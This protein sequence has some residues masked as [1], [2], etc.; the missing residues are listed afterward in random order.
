M[1]DVVD[2]KTRSRMMSDI[3]GKDTRL[4]MLVRSGLHRLGFRFRLHARNLPG[5]PDLVLRKHSAVVFVHGCYWHRHEGCRYATTP[6]TR[7][8]FWQE[9]FKA[10]VER[11]RR[12]QA[13][14]R[15]AGWRVFVVWECALRRDPVEAVENLVSVLRCEECTST[16]IDWPVLA[17]FA[18]L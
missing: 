3:R 11:D 13:M 6:A 8:E 1:I 10:N 15:K 4:E 18:Q 12:H 2:Q 5:K 17:H 7:P 14:L 9:K 16:T